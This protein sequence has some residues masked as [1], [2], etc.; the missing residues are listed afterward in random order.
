MKNTI[1]IILLILIP[2][3]ARAQNPQTN[4]P[5]LPNRTV[6]KAEA[7]KAEKE[8]NKNKP[9]ELPA[10]GQE[11]PEDPEGEITIKLKADQK[12]GILKTNETPGYTLDLKSTYNVRQDG[13]L[14]VEV[15]SDL[16]KKITEKFYNVKLSKEGSRSISIDLPR[17]Q[18]GFYQVRF[19]LN[20]AF[21][22]DTLKRVYG[23]D[24]K[25][26]M[27]TTISKPADF[28][29]FWDNSK[30]TLA[31]I[32]P[33][34]KVTRQP[35]MSTKEKDV[36]LVEMHSWGNAVIRGWLTI[37]IKR[38]KKLA[39][40]YRLPGY[41]I[42]MKPTMDEDEFAVFNLN[43]RGNGNS[44]D[45]LK[46]DGEYNLYR[47]NSKDEYIY[48]A[49]Y[50][51][52]VR[53]LD[54]LYSYSDFFKFDTDRIAAVGGSQGGALAIVLAGLDTRVKAVTAELPLYS[55]LRDALEISGALYP[56]R[57]SPVWMLADYAR[58]TRIFGEKRLYALWDYFD[59]VNFAP[60]VRCP[61][62]LAI[63][64]LDELVP[65][66]ASYSMFNLLGTQHKETW[67]SADLTHEV[68]NKYY[69]FQYYW[70]KEAFVMP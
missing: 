2:A 29:T 40:K 19:M 66:R 68:D 38:P 7:D 22:D 28:D 48:R 11:S 64:L 4:I 12:S 1:Y 43:I 16:G 50:M 58:R 45:A 21:Y 41:V 14:T 69:Q 52:C 54:F 61:V 34:F 9:I 60:N 37:P 49:A 62:L 24:P 33:Q 39:V 42:A 35:D 70:L 20:L 55:D 3:L 53:G 10:K 31:K 6:T 18:P 56:D 63:S 67:I 46:Y 26:I 51:D 8:K 27:P 44:K 23:V 47:I 65:P 32:D 25:K 17:Q 15:V 57:K 36:Y 5:S 13:K 59:P 30:T